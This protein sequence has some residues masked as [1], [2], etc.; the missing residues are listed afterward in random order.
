MLSDSEVLDI[1]T[2][3]KPV[4]RKLPFDD[5]VSVM[6]RPLGSTASV[7]DEVPGARPPRGLAPE[8]ELPSCATGARLVQ[9]VCGGWAEC[10]HAGVA[11]ASDGGAWAS[12]DAADGE[13]LRA[14]PLPLAP[15]LVGPPLCSLWQSESMV[16]EGDVNN[17]GKVCADDFAKAMIT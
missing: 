9:S 10:D 12:S 7:R 14:A 15:C 13:L 8:T 3:A 4:L 11:A 5:F 16:Q 1:V 2:E 6:C 17:D